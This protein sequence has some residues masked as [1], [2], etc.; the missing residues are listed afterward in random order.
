MGGPAQAPITSLPDQPW[1]QAGLRAVAGGVVVAGLTFFT[2]LQSQG[3]NFSK[4]S[5]IVAGIAA[6]AA[7]FGVLATRGIA[8]GT[9]DQL[10]K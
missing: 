6:G 5:V 10:R 4:Q 9:I 7:F 1:F 8:E 3:N 2:T